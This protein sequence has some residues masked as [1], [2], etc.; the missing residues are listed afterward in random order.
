MINGAILSL[1][2]I[3]VFLWA[4]HHYVGETDGVAI[5]KKIAADVLDGLDKD[6]P[7]STSFKLE[8]ARTCA[9]IS[10]VWA[11]N[12]RAYVSRSFEAPVWQDTFKNMKMQMAILAA[13]VALYAAVFLPV[14][15]T[16]IL[17]LRGL[18]IG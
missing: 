8:Q 15:S 2:I 13:Q 16:D 9:F 17:G 3:L 1:V 6:N 14:V 7:L 4:L 12:V 5:A 11:E 10:L 18:V